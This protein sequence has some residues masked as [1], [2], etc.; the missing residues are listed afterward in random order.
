MIKNPFTNHSYV[1]DEADVVAINDNRHASLNRFR[2][3]TSVNETD[4]K[5]KRDPALAL[6]KLVEK[7]DKNGVYVN[8]GLVMEDER[9]IQSTPGAITPNNRPPKIAVDVR[10]VT[11]T[12]GF[13]QKSLLTLKKINVSVP[14]GKIYALL[15]SSGCGK[16]TLLRCVLGRLQ[17]QSGVIRVF[18]QE[19]GSEYSPVPGPGVGY[20]PQELAL[21][22]DF[23]IKETLRYFG[24]L[25]R[26]SS[27]EIKARTKFLITLLHLPEKNRLVSQLSG[28]QQRRVSLA[29]ALVHRPPLL[30]LDEPTVGVDPVLRKAIWEHL[31]ALCREDGLTVI[32]TTHYIEEARTAETVGLMRFG[33]LLV[34]SNPEELLVRHGLPT[35]EAVFLKLC[36]LDSAQIPESVKTDAVRYDDEK[37]NVTIETKKDDLPMVIVN[38]EKGDIEKNINNNEDA[39]N[40]IAKNAISLAPNTAGNLL[41]PMSTSFKDVSARATP[42]TQSPRMSFS[43]RGSTGDFSQLQNQISVEGQR[44]RMFDLNRVMALF[45]KNSIRLKRNV[46]ILLFYFFLP[47]IQIA[48]FCI[49]IGQDP[50]NIPVAVYNAEDPPGLSAEYLSFVNPEIVVQVPYNSLEEARQAVVDGKAWA[51]LHFSHN[52]SASLNQRRI[53]AGKADNATIE[54]SNIKLYLDMS[55]QVIGFVLL[56]TFFL[57]FQSFAQDYLSILGYNPATVTLPIT[58]EKVIYGTVNPS[59]TEFMA[60]GVIILIAYYATTAL[61]ALSL[62]LERKD[63]LLERSLVAGVNSF[64]FLISHIMTQTIVLTIQE[65]FMLATTFYIFKVP[66]RGPMVWVFSLTFFQGLAGVMFGLFISSLCADEVSAAML[67]M[68]S[69]FPTIMLGGIFWPIQSMPDWMASLAAFLPQ[70]LPVESMRFILSRG[71]GVEFFEVTLGFIATWG[72]IIVYLVAAAFIFK[73]YT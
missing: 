3:L 32:I 61:T 63:G 4:E 69:F 19:P 33:R 17:P 28:G 23:T 24:Q 11:F 31:D 14:Q 7:T 40:N 54:S 35:L 26:M 64:E 9:S 13:G 6:A 16:T 58:I 36:Q 15:G 65:V 43:E 8:K 39:N 56:R 20:M 50:K 30:I 48:L 49:C 68:G 18:G 45:I 73:K 71:W 21:F 46:P 38:G 27:K 55:N 29:S 57:A 72:W 5:V 60:P 1:S 44:R 42:S 66:S 12:Y 41:I 53:M 51:A 10:D 59:M 25:Y 22:P 70:T 2:R 37:N 67:G 62:V 47:S 34:Q 52:Y